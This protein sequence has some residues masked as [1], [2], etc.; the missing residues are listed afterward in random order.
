[1]KMHAVMAKEFGEVKFKCGPLDHLI[2]ELTKTLLPRFLFRRDTA[3]TYGQDEVQ[4]YIQLFDEA[5]SRDDWLVEDAVED[6]LP[7]KSALQTSQAHEKTRS[8]S[9]STSRCFQE[10]DAR[11]SRSLCSTIA[12]MG[13]RSDNLP[14][15]AAMTAC[16][17]SAIT[18]GIHPPLK[19]GGLLARPMGPP[20]LPEILDE[21]PVKFHT[22]SSSIVTTGGQLAFPDGVTKEEGRS[23]NLKRRRDEDEIEELRFSVPVKHRRTVWLHTRPRYSA[24]RSARKS[25]SHR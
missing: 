2:R 8:L 15:R 18:P 9:F 16:N 23:R 5:L 1:M 20:P 13:V 12:E 7:P 6:Q 11:T 22:S 17:V 10:Q 19:H 25:D 4:S 3:E 14:P 21:H 24:M